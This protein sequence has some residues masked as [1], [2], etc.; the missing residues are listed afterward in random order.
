[1]VY[2]MHT[3]RLINQ[4]NRSKLC[5]AHFLG[6]AQFKT[7]MHSCT[8]AGNAALQGP[9]FKAT[10][11]RI[12]HIYLEVYVSYAKHIVVEIHKINKP[13]HIQNITGYVLT[14]P[15]SESRFRFSIHDVEAWNS[16][17]M[18]QLAGMWQFY[19]SYAKRARIIRTKFI[20]IGKM[21]EWP[22]HA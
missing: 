17:H 16:N 12:V 22:S 19:Y 6:P 5:T 13:H 8:S 21:G 11:D 10:F 9:W 1:M 15:C 7:H 14:S 20:S 4:G 3:P 2:W 18:K